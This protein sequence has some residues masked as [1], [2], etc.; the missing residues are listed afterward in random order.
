M[1]RCT[2][3]IKRLT[4]SDIKKWV[5]PVKVPVLGIR[6]LTPSEIEQWTT[7]Q[8][9]LQQQLA[10]YVESPVSFPPKPGLLAENIDLILGLKKGNNERKPNPP[11]LNFSNYVSEDLSAEMS[12]QKVIVYRSL[13]SD[14]EQAEA[15]V[16]PINVSQQCPTLLQSLLSPVLQPSVVKPVAN[17]PAQ[18]HPP[19][20]TVDV[21][22]EQDPSYSPPRTRSRSISPQKPASLQ[23]HPSTTSFS[24]LTSKL[25]KGRDSPSKL[26]SRFIVLQKERMDETTDSS[27]QVG[28]SS[29]E[30]SPLVSQPRSTRS[31]SL[32]RFLESKRDSSVENTAKNAVES[33]KHTFCSSETSPFKQ[34][35]FQSPALKQSLS[36]PAPVVLKVDDEI[37]LRVDGDSDIESCLWDEEEDSVPEVASVKPI[38]VSSRK[39]KVA[40]IDVSL[41]PKQNSSKNPKS[42]SSKENLAIPVTSWRS[43]RVKALL[44]PTCQ[45]ESQS[46]QRSK[47]NREMQSLLEASSIKKMLADRRLSDSTQCTR[48]SEFN[49]TKKIAVKDD[50]SASPAKRA[51]VENPQSNS[52]MLRNKNSSLG[53]KPQR[54]TST[55]EA[56]GMKVIHVTKNV[57]GKLRPR[58][59]SQSEKNISER[60][61]Y[62]VGSKVKISVGSQTDI[63]QSK[64]G[65]IDEDIDIVEEVICID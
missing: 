37:S 23:K 63:L 58:K 30:S 2:V 52:Y 38:S 7:P 41:V 51:R 62:T 54:T 36:M 45:K 9:C 39:R 64:N 1:K 60:I 56:S 6:P 21:D 20:T 28:R 32:T 34:G 59:L 42:T 50:M 15:D 16:P 24:A 55:S 48:S 49:S 35:M 33:M 22:G 26:E 4:K 14:F 19:V 47:P 44:T 12:Q 5:K 8:K 40:D 11:P 13:L 27:R 43:E 17:K 57:T 18:V 61:V 25:N 31:Q 3:K 29:R 53:Q 10:T 46:V 65:F